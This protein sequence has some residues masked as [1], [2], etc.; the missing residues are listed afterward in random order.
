MHPTKPH[1]W[2]PFA[3]LAVAAP[4]VSAEQSPID[5]Q[6]AE[7]ASLPTLRFDSKLGPL[8]YLLNNG[9]TIRVNYHDAPGTG[10]LMIVGDQRYQLTQFHFHRPSEEYIHGKP[11]DMVAHLMY[12]ASDGKVVGVAVLLKAGTPNAIIQQ[13]WQY[14]SL[15][16]RNR[17]ERLRSPNNNPYN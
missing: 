14:M 10:N 2:S 16:K 3:W 11:F 5:S 1:G 12:Q 6:S 7:K 13:I 4:L 17:A 8:K 9:Y 15:I